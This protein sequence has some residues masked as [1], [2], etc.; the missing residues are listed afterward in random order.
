MRRF[1]P[2]FALL[3]VAQIRNFAGFCTLNL[4]MDVS[5]KSPQEVLRGE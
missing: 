5:D 2:A 4:E 1:I 3:L